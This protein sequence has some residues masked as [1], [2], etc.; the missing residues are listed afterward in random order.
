[1]PTIAD[2]YRALNAMVA[3]EVVEKYAVCGGTA[4]LFYADTL[5]TYDI[6]IFVLLEQK[7]FLIDI[8][9]VYRWAESRGYEVHREHLLIHSVPVQVLDAGAGLELEAVQDANQL[10]YDGVPVPVV[11]PEYLALLYAKAGGRQRIARAVD[12]VETVD[13]DKK[14]TNDLVEKYQLHAAWQKIELAREV[15]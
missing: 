1:M 5:R 8:G 4:A 14:L 9:P 7:G 6:D 11:R 3:E 10:D 12:L 13:F 2:V 15:E